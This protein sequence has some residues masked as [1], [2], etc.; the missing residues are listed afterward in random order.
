MVASDSRRR[1][2]RGLAAGGGVTALGALLFGDDAV[3]T[4]RE[5]Q[6][7]PRRDSVWTY[8]SRGVTTV[9][10]AAPVFAGSLAYVPLGYGV[11][12]GDEDGIP[13]VAIDAATGREQW[14]FTPDGDGTGIPLVTDDHL[15][16]G[17]GSDKVV[18]FDRATRSRRWTYDAGGQEQYGG[19]AWGKPALVGETLVVGI[20]HSDL[21]DPDPSDP[22]QYANRIVGLHAGDGRL[23]WELTVDS[24]VFAGPTTVS[25]D[26]VAVT[27]S[28][29]LYRLSAQDGTVRWVADTAASVRQAPLIRAGTV[30]VNG[31]SRV[32]AHDLDTG[33]RNWAADVEADLLTWLVPQDDSLVVGADRGGVR[34]ISLDGTERWQFEHGTL[35]GGLCAVESTVYALAQTGRLLALD[36]ADGSLTD[37]S[38]LVERVSDERCGWFPESRS[39]SGLATD[40]EA[41]YPATRGWIRQYSLP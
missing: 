34:K 28:G 3:R 14:R 19:G 20:S 30:Y 41:L 6:C 10:P 36:A 4:Y 2:L 37:E 1:L 26:V 15:Y 38:L 24:D 16:V 5:W 21:S 27:K 32:V 7:P 12:T 17:T 18:A 8:D 23:R 29:T 9:L 39:V 11:T 22:D 31:D 25:N 13:L 40:G 35:L 33:R